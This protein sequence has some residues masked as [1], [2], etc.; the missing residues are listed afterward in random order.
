MITER[1]LRNWRRDALSDKAQ[2]ETRLQDENGLIP[3]NKKILIE[4]QERILRLTAE[5]L[6]QHLLERSKK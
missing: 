5:L 6:D 1:T 4:E 3:V 2:I